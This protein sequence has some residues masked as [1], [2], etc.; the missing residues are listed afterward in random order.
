M[1]SV[2]RLHNNSIQSEN[3]LESRCRKS[4]VRSAQRWILLLLGMTIAILTVMVLLIRFSVEEFIQKYASN[5][6]E[7]TRPMII[8]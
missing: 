5:V 2:L 7:F 8:V 4:H 3:S 1:Q 6:R